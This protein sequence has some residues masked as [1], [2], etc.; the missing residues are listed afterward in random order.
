MAAATSKGTFLFW[1]LISSVCGHSS[2]TT[3]DFILDEIANER[4]DIVL[5]GN[6]DHEFR[7]P[8]VPTV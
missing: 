2:S 4:C 1:A 5:V 7:L 8:T 6:F 3:A